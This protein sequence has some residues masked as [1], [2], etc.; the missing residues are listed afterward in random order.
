MLFRGRISVYLENHTKHIN[1][2]CGQSAEFWYAKASGT[3][4]NSLYGP[5]ALW[6]LDAFLIS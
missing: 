4:S 1:T 2:L 5:T 6:I 3:Y